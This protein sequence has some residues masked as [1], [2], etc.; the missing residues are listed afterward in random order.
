[1]IQDISSFGEAVGRVGRNR[2]S[3]SFKQFVDDVSHVCFQINSVSHIFL[4]DDVTHTTIFF[5]YDK[6]YFYLLNVKFC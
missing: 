3:I 6:S 5:S 2:A 1:M 4:L